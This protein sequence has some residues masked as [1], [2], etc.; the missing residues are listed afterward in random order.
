M[1]G[2]HERTEPPAPPAAP[3]D[4]GKT[5][6]AW[7]VWQ[8]WL[9]G[10]RGFALCAAL[11]MG[12]ALVFRA[13]D[14]AQPFGT[15]LIWRYLRY[16]GL[17]LVWALACTSGGLAVLRHIPGLS[18]PTRERWA[19][20]FP[21]G[22]LIFGGIIEVLGV[23]GVLGTPVFVLLPLPLLA[24]GGRRL[25]RE[26]RAIARALRR[27]GALR[28]WDLAWGAATLIG[29]FLLYA[30]IVAPAHA[31]YDA[32]W[33]H[34]PMA[35]AY[36]ATGK[37]RAFPEAW[38]IGAYPQLMSFLYTWAFLYPRSILFDRVGLAA[39]LEL[40]VLVGA[41]LTLPFVARRAS[42]ARRGLASIPL[43]LCF[44]AL[45]MY[46]P[47]CEA[48]MLA[49]L[50]GVFTALSLLRFWR[51]PTW[52]MG[53]LVGVAMGG[54]LATKYS[55]ACVL[56][57]AG[58]IV[59][60][61]LLKT[62]PGF[63]PKARLRALGAISGTF[64]LASAGHWL[65]N[66]AFYGDPLFP[67]LVNKLHAHPVTAQ[68]REILKWYWPHEVWRP[69]ADLVG[70]RQAL[71]ASVD[72][73][74]DP[75]EYLSVGHGWPLFGFLFTAALL[76]LP[77]A[78][79]KAEAWLLALGA[80]A[81][82]FTWFWV[83]HQDRY[84]QALLGWMVPVA[85]VAVR[86]AW[87]AGLLSRVLVG[88][89]LT[90]QVAWG[91]DVFFHHAPLS[92]VL[93]LITSGREGQAARHEQLDVFRPMA[94]VGRAL[95]PHATVLVHE[96]HD[97]LGLQAASVSDFIGWQTGIS[98]VEAA[99]RDQLH[100]LL[101]DRMKVTHVLWRPGVSSGMAS[102]GSDL[103]FFRYVARD[104]ERPTSVGPFLLA[105]LPAAAPSPGPGP[106][107]AAVIA[108]DGT[109]ATGVYA[110]SSL[111][112]RTVDPPP[113]QDYPRPRVPW[114]GATAPPDHVSVVAFDGGCPSRPSF[115]AERGG[116]SAFDLVARRGTTE[117]WVRR[118]QGASAH[119]G[120]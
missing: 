55:T 12:V 77:F 96:M 117:I 107:E 74:F 92:A 69:S 103:A 71:V 90:L 25:W 41:L 109:Y 94:E 108:C 56:A 120:P 42:G 50:F 88:V 76:L 67:L 39:H 61:R 8:K 105:A 52:Q 38:I 17:T 60:I 48:D 70:L 21:V 13:T 40:A 58:L 34:L 1:N 64:A 111:D 100:A 6:R 97:H 24:L 29:L 33:Y 89:L 65:K 78:R 93:S 91:G 31:G 49:V 36:A 23:V 102:L 5:P 28:P 35:E 22:V 37:I 83:H 73:A 26:A 19:M 86:A 85:F 62:P 95:P 45:F 9:G 119:D 7:D 115:L 66:W 15:W 84:L 14:A 101:H 116:A 118:G 113:A 46:G 59:G 79:A 51:S 81:G 106:D 104:L 68:G 10:P 11:A 57:P 43:A 20:S 27:P 53:L 112:V 87:Q 18:V 4:R 75:H 82:V 30:K 80:T 47:Q 16:V 72:F 98:Y 110:L 99:P 54:L 2:M 63:A 114:D 3:D 32:R 44:P